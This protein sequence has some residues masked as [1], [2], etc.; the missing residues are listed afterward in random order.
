MALLPQN[1]DDEKK[2]QAG[3]VGPVPIAKQPQKKGTGFT[4]LNR[5]MQANQ[6]NRL[7]QTVAGGVSSAGQNLQ[8]GIKQSQAGFQ[9]EAEKNRLDT[10]TNRAQ[11]SG[12]LGRF[13]AS[14]YKPDESK[15]QVSTG[16]QEQ[17]GGQKTELEKQ[18]AARQTSAT[19]QQTS[20]QSRLDADRANL[21]SNRQRY[22]DI[23]DKNSFGG[24]IRQNVL[25][26]QAKGYEASIGSL[27]GLMGVQQAAATAAQTQAAS[28]L[29]NLESQ[30]GTMSAAEKANFMKTETDRLMAEN[31]PTG[32]EITDFT[33]FQ[34]GA[35]TGP[36]ELQDYQTLIGKAQ[37]TQQLGDL[38][39]SSGGRQE[40]LKQ[41]VGGRDY[42]QGQQ[43]LDQAILGQDKSSALSQAAKQVR[44]SEKSVSS[45]N[46]LAGAQAQDLV[47]KAKAFGQETQGMIGEKRGLISAD[48][49]KQVAALQGTETQRA[50]N[51]ASIQEMLTS[52]DPK[53]AKLDK[54]TRMGLALQSAAD[55][56]YLSPQEAEQLVGKG[57]LVQRA[58]TAGLDANALLGERLKSIMAQG[59]DRRAG[60][61]GAQEGIITAMDKLAGKVG[62]DVE[63]G[64]GAEQ[65][66]AGKTNF[67]VNSLRDYI[68]KTE[69][70]KMKDP[71]Y[72]AQM[73]KLGM[74][75]L[76]QTVGG[77]GGILGTGTSDSAIA[78]A[79]AP[80]L[81]AGGV[82]A[83]YG[84]L[85]GAQAA[86][87]GAYGAAG[88]GAAAPVALIGALGYDALTGGD[89]TAKAAEG[90][91]QAASG[92]AGMSLQG[93]DAIYKA[94]M[95]NKIGN[96]A[97]GKQLQKIMDYESQLEKQGLGELTKEGMNAAG[98]F[99]DL[100]Q[101]GRLDQ[102]L[103][104]LTGTQT[105]INVAKNVAGA[106][107][108]AV[109][110]V[111]KAVSTAF[112]GGSTG[113]WA[114]N[115]LNTIDATT[116]KKV[117]IGT[118][119]NKSSDAILK[120]M[121]N[122]TQ[123]GRTAAQFKGRSEG[124]MQMNELL[125]Y[126]NAALKREKSQK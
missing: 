79:L 119:A 65:Y 31:A 90:G 85:A 60:A 104:K 102:A 64:S 47:G 82:G 8:S 50:K 118:Y 100:T 41:F 12:V 89:S 29:A 5:I 71:K 21:A 42:T 61:T 72:A 51:A 83:A 35:Y 17:Y 68:A 7:G 28:T 105:G 92:I 97:A 49:D 13:D 122:T 69:A 86:G 26:T 15:F 44:G 121:L 96:S 6:G 116:G 36:K 63:F 11:R 66:Q 37:Q 77:L 115:D 38:S 75:P 108:K 101:T 87:M 16:L 80:G 67:D 114:A 54:T 111:G 112:G 70:E 74:T 43:G 120:Q 9:T 98:G 76:Q 125:K 124:A 25:N 53:Y 110:D 78:G 34:T 27:K 56:G 48:I 57:G 81:L 62:P 109:G 106:A 107:G 33:K 39:R 45:A 18:E 10:D 46:A 93:K 73:Q 84:G 3:A 52:A 1:E 94:L 58:Q 126:Y 99:R 14:T 32:Q 30:Y 91:V 123:M 95:N 88:M 23:K 40:L 4:N 113:N 2:A 20:I 103:M 22:G 24:R 55:A 59:I 117:K 19:Q